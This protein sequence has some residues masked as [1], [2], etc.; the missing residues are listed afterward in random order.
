M[1]MLYRT[2]SEPV[3]ATYKPPTGFSSATISQPQ[4]S[5]LPNLFS[6]TNRASKQ[7]WHLTLPAAIPI[8]A[9]KATSMDR[10]L[11][12]STV[13]THNGSEYGFFSNTKTIQNRAHV[14]LP[15]PEHNDYR[16]APKIITRSLHLQQMLNL[17]TLGK[18]AKDNATGSQAQRETGKVVH[19]QPSGL[20]MRYAPLGDESGT[21]GFGT[22]SDEDREPRPAE[23]VFRMPPSLGTAQ[24]KDK[25]RGNGANNMENTSPL[26]SSPKKRRI[27]EVKD[28][29][30]PETPSKKRRK[31]HRRDEGK[32]MD[33]VGETPATVRIGEERHTEEEVDGHNENEADAPSANGV[34]R[35]HEGE[36]PEEKAKRKA[37]KHQ[38]KDEHNKRK[39]E[40]RREKTESQESARSVAAEA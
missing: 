37:E 31:K 4:A 40:K 33:V 17:P 27:E 26:K 39:E 23:A 36:T 14:F 15:N 12:G 13:V 35:R 3:S 1:L 6:P 19:E 32:E 9:I 29:V 25:R 11:R 16:A 7:V 10:I 20:K 5:D 21:L 18:A 8:S 34:T 38:R 24:L 22:S 28:D 2:P 30:A